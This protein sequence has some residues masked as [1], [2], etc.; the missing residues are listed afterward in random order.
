M[1]TGFGFDVHAFAENRKLILGGVE[2]P[3]TKGLLGH[4]DADVLTHAIMDALLGAAAE[5]DIGKH[6]P[7]T[8][9]EFK[10][11]FSM[12]LL[13]KTMEIIRNKGYEV[14]NIDATVA[15]ERPKLA[16]YIDEMV[17]NYAQV[18]NLSS[19]DINVKATTTEKLGFTGRE[20]GIAAF[21]VCTIY[22]EEKK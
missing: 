12:D 13:K 2:I 8:S 20:E 3:Y 14:N 22:M 21:A 15:A 7:D 9:P 16:G 1:R 6:F 5:G 11:A 19:E 10:G 18:M 4:S 17:N